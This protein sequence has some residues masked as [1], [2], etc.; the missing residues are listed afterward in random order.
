MGRSRVDVFVESL[1]LAV[2]AELPTIQVQWADDV[3]AAQPNL[4]GRLEPIRQNRP[5]STRIRSASSAALPWLRNFPPS[6]T[7]QPPMCALTSRTSP[8]ASN[9]FP[10]STEWL[11]R[12]RRVIGA[13]QQQRPP[14]AGGDRAVADL[15][16]RSAS[17]YDR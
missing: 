1:A 6:R 9:P 4:S 7:S 3:P 17:R 14:F 10:H 16:W 2:V 8:S 12:S 5:W 11:T 13:A 15:P